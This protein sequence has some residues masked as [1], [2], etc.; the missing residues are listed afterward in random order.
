ML[1]FDLKMRDSLTLHFSVNKCEGLANE[2]VDAHRSFFAAIVS[3]HRADACNDLTGTMASIDD[4]L[5]GRLGLA[6]IGLVAR[7]PSQAGA[8][9]GHDRR[10]W[11]VNF[12]RDRGGHHCCRGLSAYSCELAPRCSQGVFQTRGL[13]LRFPAWGDV[14]ENATHAERLAVLVE[15]DTGSGKVPAKLATGI[16]DAKF[17]SRG[18][19]SCGTGHSHRRDRLLTIV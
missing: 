1:Q 14:P 8:G 5:E 4:A 9:I 16:N 3:E 2:I 12:V 6:E 17:A 18:D 15:L 10:Q 19:F 13:L 7:E 11:L